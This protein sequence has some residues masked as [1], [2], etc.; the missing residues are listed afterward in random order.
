VKTSKKKAG[1]PLEEGDIMRVKGTS[2]LVRLV[3][4]QDSDDESLV[5]ANGYVYV[6]PVEE[7]QD[8]YHVSALERP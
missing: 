4:S 6:E 1:K 8:W 7:V 5:D 3:E 2:L